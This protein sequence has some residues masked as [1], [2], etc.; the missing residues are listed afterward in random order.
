MV[1]LPIRG[2]QLMSAL[3]TEMVGGEPYQYYPLGNY[4]VVSRAKPL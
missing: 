3:M 1:L 4:A 2:E